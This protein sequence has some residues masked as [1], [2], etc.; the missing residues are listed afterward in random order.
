M[1]H[2]RKLALLIALVALGGCGDDDEGRVDVS[3]GGATDTSTTGTSTE[4]ARPT[5]P[6]VATISVAETEFRLSP[7]NPSV[8]K[9]GVVEFKVANA[10]KVAH[11]L[12]VEGPGGEVETARIEPG[13]DATLKA[14]LGKAGRYKWYCPIGDHQDRG[15]K[16]EIT[17]AGG[18]GQK[19]ED[20][21]A[22][23]DGH[24]GY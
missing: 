19:K 10:G 15:M 3:G 5:G 17:V 6:A 11:A 21:E 22:G 12:E 23:P 9:A 8:A 2:R 13:D 24:G 7:A 20:R 16:G 18:G 4:Q 14:D 1:R